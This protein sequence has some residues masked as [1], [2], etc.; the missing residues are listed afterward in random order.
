MNLPT[1][2]SPRASVEKYGND[3]KHVESP[4]SSPD[5]RDF[6]LSGNPDGLKRDLSNRKV[7]LVAIGGSIGTALFLSIGGV[8]HR[9]G[10]GSLFLAFLVYNCMLA[11]VNNCMAEMSVYMPVSGGFIRMAGHWVDE[12]LGFMV[13][14]NFFFYQVVV[15]PFEITALSLVLSYWSEDIPVAAICGGCIVLYF[16]LNVYAVAVYGEAEFWLSSGKVLLITIL[17]VFA[18]VAMVGG[19]PQHDAFGFRYWKNPGAFAE[20]SS[21]G[22]LGKFEGFLA[23]LWSASFTC[24][25]PEYVSMMAAEAKHPRVY[26]KTAFKIVYWRLAFF[27]L[28]GALA[29]GILVPYNDPTLTAIYSVGS[30]SSGSAAASPYIIAMSNLG[31]KVLPHIITT[32]IA[33]TIFSAGNTYTYCATRSLYSLAL[34]GRAPNFLRRC[35]KKGVPIYCFLIVMLFPFFSFLQLSNSS[36]TV[37]G[38]LINL[39]T[40]AT[41]IDYVVICITYIRFHKACKAQGFDRSKLPYK[42]RFQPWSGYIGLVWMIL[43]VFCY[44]YSSFKPWDISSFFTNYSMLILSPLLFMGWKVTHRTKL[45][46]PTE[47]DLVW[48]A[49]YIT[50]YEEALNEPPIGFF[51]DVWNTMRFKKASRQVEAMP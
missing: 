42:G 38:W 37:L 22:T 23:A 50:A 21:T 9:S 31:I 7:Q 17:F 49:P 27:F 29:V 6:S 3:L 51:R 32:L 12:A 16:C 47:V 5:N 40:G 34:E 19:N 46:S 35:T 20:Y 45:I 4:A 8:L 10:P 30:G 33:T 25:G 1:T 39:A 14:W 11:L 26:V 24:V 28:G 2:T 15:I 43:V 48:D 18:F 41:V 44:G 13:G 36:A